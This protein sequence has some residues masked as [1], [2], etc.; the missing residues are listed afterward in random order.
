MQSNGGQQRQ[1][2]PANK[3]EAENYK[4]LPELVGGQAEQFRE[5]LREVR[6]NQ[7]AWREVLS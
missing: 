7:S 6:L 1:L 3:K 2:K 5:A 4:K